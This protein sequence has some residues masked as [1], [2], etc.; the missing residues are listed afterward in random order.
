M[1][2]GLSDALRRPRV[3]LFNPERA[4]AQGSIDAP[5]TL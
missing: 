2:H 5:V 3:R 1:Q 4:G